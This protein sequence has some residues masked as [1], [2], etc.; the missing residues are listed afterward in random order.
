MADSAFRG[1]VREGSGVRLALRRAGNRILLHPPPEHEGMR[2]R[3][4]WRRPGSVARRVA[5]RPRRRLCR[6][7]PPASNDA[8][9][10]LGVST[11]TCRD[12][13]VTLGGRS[14][15]APPHPRTPAPPHSRTPHPRTT[16]AAPVLVACG[17]RSLRTRIPPESVHAR[18]PDWRRTRVAVEARSVQRQRTRSSRWGGSSPKRRRGSVRSLATARDRVFG[19]CD[20]TLPSKRTRPA[21]ELWPSRGL[22]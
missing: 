1:L 18:K 7:T 4:R 2:R 5:L 12:A 15:P 11:S 16:A 22:P 17:A 14:T 3:R 19:G 13:G 20:R 8:E 6:G 9:S 10:R 21:A